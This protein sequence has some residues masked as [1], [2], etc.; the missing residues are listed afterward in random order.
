MGNFLLILLRSRRCR[1]RRTS[2]HK[3]PL[4][5]SEGG[6]AITTALVMWPNG[7]AKVLQDIGE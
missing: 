7:K 3:L 5:E 1:K 6:L 2:D 4:L